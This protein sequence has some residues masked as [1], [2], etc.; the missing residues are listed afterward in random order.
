MRIL[1]APK[2]FMP[3]AIGS[4]A[5]FTLDLAHA[6]GARDQVRIL[7]GETDPH[8]PW[9]G[10]AAV[11]SGSYEGIETTTITLPPPAE[12]KECLG[13]VNPLAVEAFG[14][15]LDDFRPDLVHFQDLGALPAAAVWECGERGLPVALTL[16]DY[17]ATCHR[18]S[19]I[20]AGGRACAGPEGGVRCAVEGCLLLPG[21]EW[22]PLTTEVRRSLSSLGRRQRTLHRAAAERE[23]RELAAAEPPRPLWYRALQRVPQPVKG[24][25]PTWLRHL[26]RRTAVGA[27]PDLWEPAPPQD[28]DALV[29]DEW[30]AAH[31]RFRF[32]MLERTLARV[33]LLTT[34]SPAVRGSLESAGGQP[35]RCLVLADG[36]SRERLAGWARKAGG[37]LTFAYL[38]A[39][40]P[41]RGLEALVRAFDRLPPEAARLIIA[42]PG[43]SDY[44]AQLRGLAGGSEVLFLGRVAPHQL[45]AFFSE[46]DVVVLPSARREPMPGALS[47]ARRLRLPVIAAAAGDLAQTVGAQGGGLTYPPGDVAAL[48]ACL[49]RFVDEPGLAQALGAVAPA[50]AT[51]EEIAV[52][53]REEYERLIA[54]DRPAGRR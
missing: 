44:F 54:S 24:L 31:C 15:C 5:M 37:R 20:T 45:A 41:A 17:W 18:R 26:A 33:G 51:A 2:S 7:W 16:R 39:V 21:D 35:G 4:A 52:R 28:R 53:L 32:Q 49:G 29:W 14:A 13:L 19:L 46:V 40:H 43:D 3:T 10:P 22:R 1:L 42:G 25:A 38:G 8:H 23:S 36:P 27:A 50:V 11:C 6:L 47:Y 12:P 9:E 34:P 30:A 48:Q